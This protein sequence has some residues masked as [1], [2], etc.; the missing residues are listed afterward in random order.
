MLTSQIG[1]LM[2]FTVKFICESI[3]QLISSVY[4]N[5]TQEPLTL[6]SNNPSTYFLLPMLTEAP[7]G[8]LQAPWDWQRD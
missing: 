3:I 4:E 8:L 1:L 6:L 5:A 2:M 7:Q